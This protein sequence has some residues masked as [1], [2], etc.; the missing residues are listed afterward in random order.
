MVA[1]FET[2]E[3]RRRTGR[4]DG[5]PTK[6]IPYEIDKVRLCSSRWRRTI[7]SC[8]R[9]P[10]RDTGARRL[11]L[12]E[13]A[14]A[15]SAGVAR[16]LLSNGESESSRRSPASG[17]PPQRGCA[18]RRP[19][20]L[21]PPKTEPTHTS[22]SLTFTASRVSPA[23]PPGHCVKPPTSASR[24]A[25]PPPAPTFRTASLSLT[26]PRHV[27]PE[28]SLHSHEAFKRPAARHCYDGNFSSSN[29]Q[30]NHLLTPSRSATRASSSRQQTTASSAP[31]RLIHKHT[32]PT[33][34]GE[35]RPTG[36]FRLTVSRL[37]HTSSSPAAGASL[38]K[39]P[40]N[41][42]LGLLIGRRQQAGTA[43]ARR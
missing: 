12:T 14:R 18:R 26:R 43:S 39:A 42:S 37:F 17:R 21:R 25:S 13:C 41:P 7:S 2:A 5:G 1:T 20:S 6:I 8:R 19:R 24:T 34:Y 23:A 27:H 16:C 33:Q 11:V 15:R 30:K 36:R 35:R 28:F 22:H 32:S 29:R 38:T 40:S 3:T 31:I 4:R 9:R 10:R